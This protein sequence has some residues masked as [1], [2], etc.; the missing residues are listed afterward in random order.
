[1]NCMQQ[2]YRAQSS[3]TWWPLTWCKCAFIENCLHPTMTCDCLIKDS[4]LSPRQT[5]AASDRQ[6]NSSRYNKVQVGLWQ[7]SLHWWTTQASCMA[8]PNV[9]LWKGSPN[10]LRSQLWCLLIE[11]VWVLTPCAWKD[12]H[13]LKFG[14]LYRTASQRY[15]HHLS[16][17]P[18]RLMNWMIPHK[19][20][21][22][23]VKYFQ[24]LFLKPWWLQLRSLLS[25]RHV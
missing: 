17:I 18:Q 14:K 21:V 4:R 19:A 13:S 15:V 1:M 2:L 11:C 20:F 25:A 3:S 9:K 6:V 10:M 12:D 7:F 24:L 8:F 22:S 5:A 23:L 16:C